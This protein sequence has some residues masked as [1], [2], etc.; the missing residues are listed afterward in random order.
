[1]VVYGIKGYHNPCGFLCLETGISGGNAPTYLRPYLETY[2]IL[3][4]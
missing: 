4:P 1:M 3:L 2:I